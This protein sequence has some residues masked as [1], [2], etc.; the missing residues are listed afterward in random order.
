MKSLIDA[1]WYGSRKLTQFEVS[2]AAALAMLLWLS[3]NM[4]EAGSP[5][6][7]LAYRYPCYMEG[8]KQEAEL[9][10]ESRSDAAT[11]SIRPRRS[12]PPGLVVNESESFEQPLEVI[13]FEYFS[14]C[15]QARSL[16]RLSAE[17]STEPGKVLDDQKLSRFLV[18]ESDC[19]AIN[20]MRGE[21]LLRDSKGFDLIFRVFDFE[22][23]KQ[24]YLNVPFRDR[25][26]NIR[27]RCPF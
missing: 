18:F 8:S 24:S 21:G 26:N 7:E 11:V 13:T 16:M 6:G 10:F 20:R 3:G 27:K 12:G 2:L 1:L 23:A 22:R 5:I 17:R 9:S 14:A 25:A 19:E 4:A 15:H